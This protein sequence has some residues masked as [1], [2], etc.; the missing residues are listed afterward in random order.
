[1]EEGSSSAGRWRRWRQRYL[2][3]FP[4]AVDRFSSASRR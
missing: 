1:M 2:C 4:I 3:Y